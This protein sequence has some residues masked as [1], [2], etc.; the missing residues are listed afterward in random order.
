LRRFL[1]ENSLSLFFFAIFVLA[2]VGQAIAGHDVFN[3]QQLDHKEPAVS[4]WRY[5]A[6]SHFAQ[7]VTENWQS[8]YLQFALFA[9]ATVWLLQKGSPESK[10][11]DQAGT[12]TDEE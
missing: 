4:F 6:S 12:E 5:I 1:K 11:L 10:E 9:L 8:E 3:Q 2:L 7:A